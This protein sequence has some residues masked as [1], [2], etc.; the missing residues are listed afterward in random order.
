M[1]LYIFSIE[2][3]NIKENIYSIISKTIQHS[4]SNRFKAGYTTIHL[5]LKCLSENKLSDRHLILPLTNQ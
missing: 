2:T 4:L 5:K 1:I 3:M